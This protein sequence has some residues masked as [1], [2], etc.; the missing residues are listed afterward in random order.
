MHS[1][2][3]TA[4]GPE[5]VNPDQSE[6][7]ALP[8]IRS[9]SILLDETFRIPGTN[10]RFGLDPILGILPVA[11]DSVS[12]LITLYIIFEGYRADAPQSLLAKM[13]ALAAVDFFVGSIPV[14][15]TVFDAFWKNNKWSVGLLE[16]HLEQT[17]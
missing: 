13:V 15:G 11:G 12:S 2:L 10:I 14:I 3:K 6:H 5:A 7:P 16:E 9:L 17:G 8:R 1:L 4:A